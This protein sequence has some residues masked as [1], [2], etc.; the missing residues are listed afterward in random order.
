MRPASLLAAVALIALPGP[1][2]LAQEACDCVLVPPE[3]AFAEHDAVFEGLVLAAEP[4]EEGNVAELEV[5][6]EVVQAWRGV[7]T[8]EVTVRLPNDRCVPPFAEGSTWLVYADRTVAG[9]RTGT[10]SRT[11]PSADAD[12]DRAVLGAGVVPFE[13][14]PDEED[15]PALAETAPGAGGCASCTVGLTRPLSGASWAALALLLGV[16]FG[17][18]MR[19]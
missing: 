14:G 2:A 1:V 15:G 8:E 12:P 9:W 11:R 18:R 16:A 3:Q 4:V 17:R 6:F 19:P 13:V 10:C 7:D 5:R